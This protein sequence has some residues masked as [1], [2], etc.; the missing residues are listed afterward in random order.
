MVVREGEYIDY[1]K[2]E[3]IEPRSSSHQQGSGPGQGREIAES[4]ERAF[5]ESTPLGEDLTSCNEGDL[6]VDASA[7]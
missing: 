1:I 6:E 7:N 2:P 3:S 4:P 5:E